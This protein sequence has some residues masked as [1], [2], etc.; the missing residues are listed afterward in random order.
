[1]EK[2]REFLKKIIASVVLADMGIIQSSCKASSLNFDEKTGDTNRKESLLIKTRGVVLSWHDIQT[3]NWPYLAFKAGINTISF[4]ASDSILQSEAYSK[5]L[6]ECKTYKI[7]VEFEQH[8]MYD[9]L[10][11]KLLDV[12]PDFFRMDENGNRVND[13]NCCPSSKEGLQLIAENARIRTQKQKSTTGRFF[14]WMDDGGKKC[15]CPKCFELSISD[16]SLLIENEIVKSIKT[17]DSSYTLSHLAYYDSIPSPKLV[18][19]EPGIFL[20]FAPFERVWDRPLSQLNAH[21]EGV[22]ITH[23]DYLNHLDDNL[24]LFPV[25]TAQIL[26][27]WLDVSLFSGWKKPA[28]KLPWNPEVC[29]SDIETYYNKGIRHISTFAA[30]VDGD[31]QTDFKDLKFID[32]YGKF[33]SSYKK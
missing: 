10:P 6:E 20:E 19:P 1:M 29:K 32:D 14:Y 33:L 21:R 2:R 7:N 9:L 28:V 17:I 27:Y 25:E 22:N 23:G 4:H 5:F 8:A 24:K 11:R 16:Q 31:Y 30:Y 12:S 15:M 26:E 13:F 3:L 18:K